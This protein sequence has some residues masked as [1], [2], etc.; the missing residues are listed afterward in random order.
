MKIF[1]RLVSFSKPYRHYIPEYV[2][3]IFLYILFGLLNFTMLIPLF[4]V[5]FNT[6][7]SKVVEQL[8]AFSFSI[9]YFKD[10]FYFY[11]TQSV[12]SN[13]KMGVLIFVSCILLVCVL[14]KNIFGF[15]AQKVLTRMRINLVKYIR[16]KL[17]EQFS[18]QSLQFFHKEKKGDLLATISGDVVEIENT[19]VSS[20][21]T[22]FREPLV[23]I[24]T[25]IMLFYLSKE[26]TLFTL[27][28]FPVSGFVISFIS[29]KL[30]KKSNQSQS[31]LGVLLNL[32]EETISGIRII[33]TF[34]AENFVQE[35]YRKENQTLSKLTKS[36]VNQREL[37]SPISEFLGVLV[38]VVIIIYG[39]HLILNGKSHL[40]ASQFIVYITFYLQIIT[41]AKS[42][43]GAIT[44]LQRGLAAGERVIR[45]LDVPQKV[46][47]V[48]NAKKIDEFNSKIVFKNV[49]FRYEEKNV[50]SN[51]NITIP[52]GKMIALV[53]NS[54]GGKST[55]T[56]LVP[57]FYDVNE[58]AILI[59]DID[60]KSVAIK[61]L[62]NL[63]GMVSQEAIL[64]HDTIFNNIAFG[65]ESATIDQVE[66]AAK[67][68]NA[69][70]FIL[71][72]KDGYQTTVGDR[73]VLL[74]GG[75]RQR[76]TIAR[77]VLKNAPI[78]IL[79]EATSALDSESEK[80]VQNALE[81]LMENRTSIVIAHRLS[82]IKNADEII[83]LNQGVIAEQGTH[84]SLIL[85]KGIYKKLVD[86]QEIK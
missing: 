29:K 73:G 64:F 83:V 82:T 72:L 44:Y 53:G 51:I 20:I 35:R 25:F 47:E 84:E 52:K 14:F 18:T 19:V 71:Q 43:A 81:K 77:A 57:R 12:A 48:V 60:I 8:P 32:A 61:D 26:L 42:I 4:D 79:D 38:V 10:A 17:F 28:F 34:N 3:Y 21:Q 11:L 37:A 49:T 63:I 27:F 40:T 65:C 9:N 69:H 45:I 15:L 39:G 74:S 67:I 41:P 30:R 68:A 62:R 24:S 13:G 6:G 58:G 23:I 70:E 85:Q 56:D 75:Q 54:G 22:I 78:L 33:K 76:I 86:L 50:L 80:L 59:D 66:S 1:F 2:V 46:V 31:L 36:M 7:N 55:L 16:E 5:L